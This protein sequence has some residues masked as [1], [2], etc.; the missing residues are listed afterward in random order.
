MIVTKIQLDLWT[1]RQ[2]R[3]Y[4]AC[5]EAAVKWLKAKDVD[6][7][8]RTLEL[9]RLADEAKEIIIREKEGR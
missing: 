3:W 9:S 2:E 5:I 6:R 8:I 7:V 4:R 1:Y